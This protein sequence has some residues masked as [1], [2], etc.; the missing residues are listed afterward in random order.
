M[1]NNFIVRVF[2]FLK[3]ISFVFKHGSDAVLYDKGTGLLMRNVWRVMALHALK[4]AAREKAYMSVLLADMNDLK[5]LNDTRG[6][7]A[8]DALLR[9]A[10]GIFQKTMRASDIIGR[11]GGDEFIAILPKTDYQRAMIIVQKLKKI[12]QEHSLSWSMGVAS[13]NFDE[14]HSRAI[15][16]P[17]QDD[18]VWDVLLDNL[19]ADADAQLYQDKIISKQ[20]IQN[21]KQIL[22]T[23]I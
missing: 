5:K 11:Y 13:I 9:L 4:L 6:H 3:A 19:I 10:G 22:I 21:S 17:A 8:G 1:K 2:N 14:E 7:L 20:S 18:K 15:L 12:L 16:S 23:E